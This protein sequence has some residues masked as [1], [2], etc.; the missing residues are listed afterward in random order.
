MQKATE[1]I[2]TTDDVPLLLFQYTSEDLYHV[3]EKK[4]VP[5]MHNFE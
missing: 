1:M 4:F 3:T 5:S 2:S